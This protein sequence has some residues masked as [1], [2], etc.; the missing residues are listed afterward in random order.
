M[1]RRMPNILREKGHS[2]WKRGESTRQGAGVTREEKAKGKRQKEKSERTRR[3]FLLPFAFYFP[4]TRMVNVP[5]TG[6]A[7]FPSAGSVNLAVARYTLCVL[8]STAIVFAPYCVGTLTSTR[9]LA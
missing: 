5:G 8:G 2:L 3:C 9:Y 6:V 1:G 4:T 7:F